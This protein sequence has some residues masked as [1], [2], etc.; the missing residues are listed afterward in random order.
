VKVWDTVSGREPFVLPQNPGTMYGVAFVPNAPYLATCSGHGTIRLWDLRSVKEALSIHTPVTLWCIAFNPD[1][2]RLAMALGDGTIQIISAAPVVDT[3]FGPLLE[4]PHT[5][6]VSTVR[7]S[8]DGTRL[9]TIE[10]GKGSGRPLRIRVIDA[11]DGRVLSDVGLVS[12]QATA[13]A[14]NPDGK[15]LA[16]VDA[17]GAFTVRDV[18]NGQALHMLDQV[19]VTRLDYSPDGRWIASTEGGIGRDTKFPGEALSAK[20]PLVI[21][22]AGTGHMVHSLD[23]GPSNLNGLAF[24][25]DGHRVAAVGDDS[26]L[27]VWDTETGVRLRCARTGLSWVG[28]LAFSPDGRQIATAGCGE[29]GVK[30]WD[31]ATGRLIT[32]LPGHPG[33]L[34]CVAYSPDNRLLA[35]G[36]ADKTVRIWDLATGQE[37]RTL[38]GH[39]DWVTDVSFSPDGRRLASSSYDGTV[40]VWD[41]TRLSAPR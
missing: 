10:A 17:D 1:G 19:K 9:A 33:H 25:P 31:S 40:K 3:V 12:S 32:D 26:L 7:Y 37:T 36:S 27:R 16:T 38:I 29:A 15:R 11:E 22:D 8:P 30:V 5:G 18:A 28:P 41:V 34:T 6:P 20:A 4:V 2:R 35:S 39:S 21:R 23:A 14:F 13:V 24:S